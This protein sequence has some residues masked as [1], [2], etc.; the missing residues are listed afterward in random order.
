MEELSSLRQHQ[1]KAVD[2]LKALDEICRKENIQYFLDGGSC[3]GAIRHK[4]FILWDDDIDN[5]T[6]DL[7]ELVGNTISV[8]GEVI[9]YN[10]DD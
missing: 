7:N 3:L 6:F 8:Y 2:A 1:L 5:F 10:Y 4:G 9:I